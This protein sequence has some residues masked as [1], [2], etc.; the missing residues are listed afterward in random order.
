MRSRR[1]VFKQFLLLLR[2]LKG[3]DIR[4]ADI[5][6]SYRNGTARGIKVEILSED[7]PALK[8]VKNKKD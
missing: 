7:R 4:I 6:F 8:I 3:E 2:N 5:E 1:K